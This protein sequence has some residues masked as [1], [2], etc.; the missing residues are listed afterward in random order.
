MASFSVFVP[1]SEFFFRRRG[2]G[3]GPSEAGAAG[4]FHRAFGT[5]RGARVTARVAGSAGWFSSGAGV[6][7]DPSSQDSPRERVRLFRRERVLRQRPSH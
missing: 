5:A 6:R 3:G 2:G 7:R 1:I 4:R